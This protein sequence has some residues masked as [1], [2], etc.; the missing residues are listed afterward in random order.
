[1]NIFQTLYNELTGFFGIGGII[2]MVQSGDYGSLSTFEGIQHL[3]APIIP[4]LLL[5]EIIRAFFYNVL[6]R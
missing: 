5:I 3:I 4:L 2:K 1:M 6:N